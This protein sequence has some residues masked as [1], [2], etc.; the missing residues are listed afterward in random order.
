MI[1][2]AIE[3]LDTIIHQSLHKYD[4]E[5]KTNLSQYLKAIQIKNEKLMIVFAIVGDVE[6]S[7]N[8]ATEIENDCM[9]ALSNT[10]IYHS[11]MNI[12]EITDISEEEIRAQIK[13]KIKVIIT[14]ESRTTAY[15]HSTTSTNHHKTTTK[16]KVAVPGV[17]KII[18]V[19]S[20]KGG[21]GKSVV[22]S[23]I[24]IALNQ[25]KHRV[26][27]VDGDIHGPSMPRIFMIDEEPIIKDNLFIP[28]EVDGI[29]I[30]SVGSLID[31]DQAL[32]WRGPMLTKMLHR[33]MQ[34]SEW[35]HSKFFRWYNTD[36]LIVDTPPGTG[37]IHLNLMQNYDI[38]GTVVVSTPQQVAID[39]THK[40]IDMLGKLGVNILGIVE[41]MG[42]ILDDNGNKLYP[43]G[44]GKVEEYANTK[45]LK[46]FGALPIVPQVSENADNGTLIKFMAKNN[47]VEQ[48]IKDFHSII[49]NIAKTIVNSS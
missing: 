47:V 9:E 15:S 31:S 4:T 19:V 46:F 17:N 43:F 38:Y 3:T 24:A 22:S 5:N 11:I 1:T 12:N 10:Q 18:L 2:T 48:N 13:K 20:G 45:G 16:S 41:N 30:M 21:V 33:I 27:I 8:L 37:D 39:D 49:T 6:N 40:S 28:P 14:E 29:K 42:Y 7:I 32:V 25:A 35:R 26:G 34:N 36:Y 44:Q 23:S